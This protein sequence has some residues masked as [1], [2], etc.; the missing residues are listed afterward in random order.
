MKTFCFFDFETDNKDPK[1][2]RVTEAAWAIFGCDGRMIRAASSTFQCP[3]ISQEI[4]EITGIHQEHCDKGKQFPQLF[5]F[6]ADGFMLDDHRAL[7]G[8]N[9]LAYDCEIINRLEMGERLFQGKVIIDTMID[10]PLPPRTTSKRLTHLCS[11]HG[12][13]TPDAHGALYD[14]I[15]TAKLFFKYDW[16]VVIQ[17]ASTPLVY[18]EAV[19]GYEKKDLAKADGYRF[20]PGKKIWYKRVRQFDREKILEVAKDRYEVKILHNF[21]PVG[22]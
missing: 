12:I 8:H 6:L 1:V 19:T 9:V 5:S 21:T 13:V 17:R 20:D 7:V 15:Y 2:A 18:I 3:D 10:L 4:T 14:C 22:G 16:A 11:D